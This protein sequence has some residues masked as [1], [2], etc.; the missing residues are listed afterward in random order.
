[1][2]AKRAPMICTICGA[3][4]NYHADKV[5]YPESPEALKMMDAALGGVINEFHSCPGCGAGASRLAA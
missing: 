1:M 2:T 5:F 3:E 4:M